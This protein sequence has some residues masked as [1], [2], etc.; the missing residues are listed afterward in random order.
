MF[1]GKIIMHVIRWTYI[2]KPRSWLLVLAYS[3][4]SWEWG[5]TILRSSWGTWDPYVKQSKKIQEAEYSGSCH[6]IRTLEAE[7]GESPWVWGD[8]GYGVSSKPAWAPKSQKTPPK[9]KCNKKLSNKLSVP[10]AKFEP[11]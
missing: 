10:K 5:K 9:R 4:R 2:E 1:N 8:L 3:L 6:C 11:W 7:A